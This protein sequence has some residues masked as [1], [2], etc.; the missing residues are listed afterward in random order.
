MLENT[1]ISNTFG[2]I[3]LSFPETDYALNEPSFS[4]P[5]F[6]YSSFNTV[7]SYHILLFKS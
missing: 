7:S 3:K 5:K 1:I 6:Y 4:D 2:F